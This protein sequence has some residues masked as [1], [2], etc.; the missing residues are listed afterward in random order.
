[1]YGACAVRANAVVDFG[2][3]L[4]DMDMHRRIVGQS[5]EQRTQPVFGYRAQR[6]RRD[7]VAQPAMLGRRATHRIEQFEHAVGRV[8]EAALV[9]ARRL[10]AEAGELVR[11]GQ[12]RDADAGRARGI[13]HARAELRDLRIARA[14]LR[15]M[16]VVEFAHRRVAALEHLDIQPACN[17]RERVGRDLQ[18]EAVHQVAPAPEAV[19]GIRAVFGEPR[20]RALERV[21]MQVRH[22]GQHRPGRACDACRRVGV[23]RDVGQRAARVPAQQHVAAPAIGQVGMVREQQGVGHCESLSTGSG[24]S[25]S[26]P[27][28]CRGRQA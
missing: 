18:R 2:R 8:D 23:G 26:R 22:A 27:V 9:V 28:R 10:V 11:H 4:G 21:R 24:A 1:M 16:H 3:L 12:H 7:A 6:M 25:A 14:V 17:R 13:D 19:G 20:H 5:F 15:V